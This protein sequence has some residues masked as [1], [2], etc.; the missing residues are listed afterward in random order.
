LV[1]FAEPSEYEPSPADS[2]AESEPE[3]KPSP[4]PLVVDTPGGTVS[5]V[6]RAL[7]TNAS[8]DE[9]GIEVDGKTVD[10]SVK[11]LDDGI[12]SLKFSVGA[13]GGKVKIFIRSA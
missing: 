10:R 13:N 3:L 4:T 9:V 8:A 12:Y 6:L 2:P 11:I 7:Y 5:V 1:Q